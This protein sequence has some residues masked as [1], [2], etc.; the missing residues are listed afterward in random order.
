MN[1][2]SVLFYETVRHGH[3]NRHR[4][5]SGK[6]VLISLQTLETGGRTGHLGPY[7]GHQ[8]GSGKGRQEGGENLGQPLLKFLQELQ[9]KAQLGEW[10][11]TGYLE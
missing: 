3:K 9:S 6:Q 2:C 4:S 10:F 11:R 5:G 7:E 8:V 1:L